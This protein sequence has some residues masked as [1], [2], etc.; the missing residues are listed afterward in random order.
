MNP[1]S[2][3]IKTLNASGDPGVPYTI[4]AGDIHDYRESDDQLVARLVAKVGRGS[5]FDRLF[6]NAGHDIA[7]GY[8]SIRGVADERAP[9]PR[10]EHVACHHLN[11]F[12]C[13]AGLRAMAGV[14]W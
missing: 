12:A 10:K 5:L 2:D 14:E 11:Y 9:A 6:Q 1:T 7:V 3:F 13:E 4:V 8:D